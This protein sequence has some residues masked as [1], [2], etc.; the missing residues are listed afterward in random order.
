MW[1]ATLPE[2]DTIIEQTGLRAEKVTA[3]MLCL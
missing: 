2:T 1:V 3:E